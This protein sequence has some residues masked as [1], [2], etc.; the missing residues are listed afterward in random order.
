MNIQNWLIGGVS[1]LGISCLG[2]GWHGDTVEAVV[3]MQSPLVAQAADYEPTPCSDPL[4]CVEP[5]DDDP[6]AQ[7]QSLE[8]LSQDVQPTDWAYQTLRSLIERYGLLV[9]FPD[10]R[11]QGNRALT[12]NEFA[13]AVSQALELLRERTG[14]DQEQVQEDLAT[15]E[16]LQQAYGEIANDL[17]QRATQL[18]RQ[19]AQQ[20]HQQFST[21]TKLTGQTVGVLTDGDQ[22]VGTIVTRT[23]LNFLTSFTGQDSLY[24]QLEVGNNGNDAI[25]QAHDRRQNRLG[26]KGLLADGGGLD[27]VA[28]NPQAQI[29][30]LYYSFPAGTNLNMTIGARLSPR[31]FIDYNRFANDSATNFA[32][33]F[34]ANNPLIVQNQIDRPGGAGAVLTWYPNQS[35]TMRALYVTADAEDPQQGLFADKFQGSTELEYAFNKNLVVRLQYTIAKINGISISAG[36]LNT[37]W[38]LNRQF[39]VFGRLGIAGYHGFNDRLDRDLDLTPKTWVIGMTVRN[40]VIPGSTVGLALGQPFVTSDLGN[41]TQTNFEAYYSFLINDN[42]SFSPRLMIV[43][44]PD[45]DRS[46]TIWEWAI[47]MV[48][49]F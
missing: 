23:R 7:I 42:I 24:T 31:D 15:L 45:N 35:L 20:E 49:T 5:S 22:A 4:I 36:G 39:A 38:A 3:P 8:S 25:G 46:S 27:Y 30:K 10:G 18:D 44:N 32:S 47:R 37:E 17:Q 19:L 2:I 33:S 29:R 41:A 14:V 12:R 6:M 13:A 26:T 28:V 43:T 40:L 11:F 48:Y 34:F 9:G 1:Y 21:T 16:Q